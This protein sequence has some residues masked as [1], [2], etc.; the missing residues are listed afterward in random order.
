MKTMGAAQ[1]KTNILSVLKEVEGSR[2]PVTVTRNGKPIARL[3][4]LDLE[5]DPLAAFHFP[6]HIEVHGDIV[7]SLYTDEELENFFAASADQLK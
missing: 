3:V 7:N 6:G 4:P 2:E 5:E 1:F